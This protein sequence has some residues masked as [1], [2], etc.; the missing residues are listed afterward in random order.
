VFD[1]DVMM[2]P[3]RHELIF[4]LD[5]GEAR[6]TSGAVT[7]SGPS[8]FNLS[9]IPCSLKRGFLYGA[10]S[11][12]PTGEVLTSMTDA[13]EI[14]N[15][16]ARFCQCLDD[17]RFEEFSQTFT[18][19]GSF[20]DRVGRATILKWIQGAELATRPE[21]KRKHTVV[22]SIITVQGDRAEAI[23]D[24]VMFDQ[25]G[26]TPWTIRVGRYTDE[27]ARQPTGGWLFARRHLELPPSE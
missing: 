7:G 24:L 26:T 14:R 9:D 23:S 2:C 18:E 13:D 12:R 16:L 22:N 6:R 11:G 4:D 27:L 20:N 5:R 19:D 1:A 25:V 10:L 3:L 21:L 8:S 17:R 15:T